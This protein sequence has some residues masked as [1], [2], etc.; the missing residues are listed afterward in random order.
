MNVYFWTKGES[1][2]ARDRLDTLTSSWKSDLYEFKRVDQAKEADVVIAMFT[3]AA[4]SY[5]RAT[6]LLMSDRVTYARANDLYVWDTMDMPAGLWPGFYA[7]LRQSRFDRTRHRTF[8]YLGS[9]N[10]FLELRSPRGDGSEDVF[11]SFQGALSSPPRSR[12]FETKFSRKDIF[13]EK[14]AP[15]WGPQIFGTHLNDMKKR[16]VD[17]IARSRFVLCPRGNGTSSFRLFEVMQCGRVPVVISDSWVPPEGVD[18]KTCSVRIRES[19][20]PQISNILARYDSLWINMACAAR[21]VWEEHYCP[22]AIGK[23]LLNGIKSIATTRRFPER[24]YRVGWPIRI[25]ADALRRHAVSTK[26]VFEKS[27]RNIKLNT[28]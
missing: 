12:L 18:W 13:I 23:S 27:F 19:D 25:G 2:Y 3:E 7:S 22:S 14:V 16:Y 1:Q 21:R 26:I 5:S 10:Q 24:W 6:T 11:F 4:E 15:I 9:L 20:I 8:C 17:M 28:K